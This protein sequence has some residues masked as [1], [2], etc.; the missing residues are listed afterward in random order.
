M[1]HYPAGSSHQKM[2]HCAPKGMDISIYTRAVKINQLIVNVYIYIHT[3]TE[4]VSKLKQI[5]P[6]TQ[7]AEIEFQFRL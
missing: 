1:V 5:N 3:Q 4:R 7:V 2:V 6:V